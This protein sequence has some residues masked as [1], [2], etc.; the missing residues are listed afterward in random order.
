VCTRRGKMAAQ[1][2][3]A[4]PL[5]REARAGGKTQRNEEDDVDIEAIF[6]Q[7]GRTLGV[8]VAEEAGGD[9]DEAGELGEEGEA[10]KEGGKKR[11][12]TT[13]EL[14]GSI[15][16]KAKRRR[17]VPYGESALVGRDGIEALHYVAWVQ[18]GHSED[19]MRAPRADVHE[20]DRPREVPAR[21]SMFRARRG[22][23]VRDLD[24]LWALWRAW[25]LRMHARTSLED[26]LARNGRL[27]RKD[28]VKGVLV[29][30]RERDIEWR[31]S[32]RPHAPRRVDHITIDSGTKERGALARLDEAFDV[33]LFD[34]AAPGAGAVATGSRGGKKGA[35]EELSIDALL[36]EVLD[37][38]ANVPQGNVVDG[39][40][41]GTPPA[42][43]TSRRSLEEEAEGL[44]EDMEALEAALELD[45]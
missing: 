23:E 45:F 28:A 30:E 32:G 31:S 2:R 36:A 8:E 41:K 38:E 26:M 21:R 35:E 27:S 3:P 15:Q 12:K 18:T 20:Q 11:E 5:V 33:D 9:D 4:I 1:R 34:L 19:D 6:R 14:V 42:Q 43:R 22:S 25:A 29:R 24:A 40:A 17:V 39:S 10:G 13:E 7:H 16:A 44:E 37:E